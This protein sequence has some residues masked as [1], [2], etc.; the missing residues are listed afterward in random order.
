MTPCVCAVRASWIGWFTV[1][2]Q[3]RHVRCTVN[4]PR[5]RQSVLYA[6]GRVGRIRRPFSGARAVGHPPSKAAG[7]TN[8]GGLRP[9]G[10]RDA[11]M[12][13]NDGWR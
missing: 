8:A 4:S 7:R 5:R 13:N 3:A 2:Y 9:A 12:V 10:R 6:G 1:C 11:G